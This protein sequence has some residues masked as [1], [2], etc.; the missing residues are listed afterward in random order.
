M[1]YLYLS[2]ILG[3]AGNCD[4]YLVVSVKINW[5][6]MEYVIAYFLISLHF[7]PGR[8]KKE[9]ENQKFKIPVLEALQ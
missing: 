3:K 1:S 5:I 9:A 7:S 2:S 8:R 4:T 6:I